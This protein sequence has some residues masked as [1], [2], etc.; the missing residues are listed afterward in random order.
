MDRIRRYHSDMVV[1]ETRLLMSQ[2]K[3]AHLPGNGGDR[4]TDGIWGMT[5]VALALLTLTSSGWAKNDPSQPANM[6]GEAKSQDRPT[7][8]TKEPADGTDASS[9]GVAESALGRR[10][11]FVDGGARQDLGT[12][13]ER[14]KRGPADDRTSTDVK[15]LGPMLHLGFLAPVSPSVRLGGAFGY[16]LNHRLT[17]RLT[18]EERDDNDEP[19]RWQMGQLLSLDFRL[20]W[21]GQLGGPLSL[22]VTPQAGI[23]GIL[24]GGDLKQVSDDLD[25]SLNIWKG[26]R[27]GLLAGIDAGLR[28]QYNSWFSIKGAAGYL[29]TAQGLLHAAAKG[30]GGD[31]KQTWKTSGS[32]LVGL[33]ALE[34]GF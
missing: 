7:S 15:S 1:G 3:E 8:E 9:T 17:E 12:F 29:Y 22:L 32:R 24:A 25:G 4:W 16:G 2:H 28:Y 30:E 11:V 20:E 5:W 33:F 23:T 21:S 10:L 13:D 6:K 27:L 14:I 18:K 19:E 31:T 34:A 26:P